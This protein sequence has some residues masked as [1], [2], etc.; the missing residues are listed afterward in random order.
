MLCDA[1]ASAEAGEVA[2]AAS[3]RP[4]PVSTPAFSYHESACSLEWVWRNRPEE[5]QHESVGLL[6]HWGCRPLRSHS[7]LLLNH[8]NLTTLIR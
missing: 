8:L 2:M 3:L 4:L 6:F 7:F 1:A 5:I